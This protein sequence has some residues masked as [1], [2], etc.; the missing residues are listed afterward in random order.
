MLTL[1]RTFSRTESS[2][3]V[4]PSKS[5]I[6]SQRTKEVPAPNLE[7]KDFSDLIANNTITGNTLY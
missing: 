5:P 1:C 2:S 3:N 7:S 4:V 6:G